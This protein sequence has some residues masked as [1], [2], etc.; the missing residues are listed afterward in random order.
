MIAH[1]AFSIEGIH[2]TPFLWNLHPPSTAVR[3]PPG[4]RSVNKRREGE[5]EETER[6]RDRRWEEGGQKLIR[7]ELYCSSRNQ[8]PEEPL[9]GGQNTSQCA[10][11]A[12]SDTSQKSAYRPLKSV[13]ESCHPGNSLQPMKQVHNDDIFR[14]KFVSCYRKFEYITFLDLKLTISPCS[15]DVS[16][17]I[18][19]KEVGQES[20]P[21]FAV[22][23]SCF[24]RYDI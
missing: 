13:T 3:K 4:N 5:R 16:L 14:R 9:K 7:T 10:S 12:H 2:E 8:L 15:I 18:V 11:L 24:Q 23:F 21:F 17:R 1:W 22:F 19:L 20:N 6:K